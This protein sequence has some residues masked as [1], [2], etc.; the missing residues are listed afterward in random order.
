MLKNSKMGPLRKVPRAGAPVG[1][2][3]SASTRTQRVCVTATLPRPHS[4]F[5]L[6]GHVQSP[7]LGNGF[8]PCGFQ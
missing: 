8:T 2:P 1:C 5:I 6:R 7:A 3:R 4:V